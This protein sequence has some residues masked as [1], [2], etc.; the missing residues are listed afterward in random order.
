MK[1]FPINVSQD[2][3]SSSEG[4]L[5]RIGVLAIAFADGFIGIYSIP[6]PKGVKPEQMIYRNPL[7]IICFPSSGRKVVA[8]CLEWI[9]SNES[10]ILLAGRSDGS[11][12]L[13]DT[14]SISIANDLI[15]TASRCSCSTLLLRKCLHF[16]LFFKTKDL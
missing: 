16:F 2:S 13:F 7:P 10:P 15:S 11:V 14:N 5:G 4:H 12:V 3:S 6:D 1:W 8:L 9:N